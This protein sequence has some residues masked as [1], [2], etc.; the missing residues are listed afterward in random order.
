M[1]DYQDRNYVAGVDSVVPEARADAWINQHSYAANC[2]ERAVEEG[3]RAFIRSD[4]SFQVVSDSKPDQEPYI[5]SYAALSGDPWTILFSCNCP[6]GQN[7]QHLPIPCKHSWLAGRNL[8]NRG[9][10]IVDETMYLVAPEWRPRPVALE[11]QCK[12]CKSSLA[13]AQS[14]GDECSVCREVFG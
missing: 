8:V 6:S 1:T 7:R 10:A 13:E 9:V 11:R 2:A 12:T 3:H 4:A 14:Y 5:V